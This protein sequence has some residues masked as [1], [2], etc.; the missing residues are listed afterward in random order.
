[1][2]LSGAYYVTLKWMRDYNSDHTTSDHTGHTRRCWSGKYES[3]LFRGVLP[4]RIMVKQVD[5]GNA[6]C[7]AVTLDKWCGFSGPTPR[8]IS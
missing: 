3:D 7:E 6:A 1:M 2:A 8:R 4:K 5:C